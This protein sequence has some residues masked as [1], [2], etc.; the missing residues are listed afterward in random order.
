M[1]AWGSFIATSAVWEN[2]W[3]GPSGEKARNRSGGVLPSALPFPLTPLMDPVF[4]FQG[5]PGP[6]G[7]P[8]PPGQKVSQALGWGRLPALGWGRLP[9]GSCGAAPLNKLRPVFWGVATLE[10]G[11]EGQTEVVNRALELSLQKISG[12]CI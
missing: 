5:R 12:Y 10:L 9:M 1:W 8:G 6:P 2:L 4:S 11:N 3:R 7:E